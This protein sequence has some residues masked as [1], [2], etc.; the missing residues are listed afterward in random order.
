MALTIRKLLVGA[1]LAG[2]AYAFMAWNA[3]PATIEARML[4]KSARFIGAVQTGDRATVLELSQSELEAIEEAQD[5]VVVAR[6]EFKVEGATS[7][8]APAPKSFLDPALLDELGRQAHAASSYSVNPEPGLPSVTY[9]FDCRGRR[10]RC[11]EHLRITYTANAGKISGWIAFW[12]E[13]A[14][15]Q[16]WSA[17]YTKGLEMKPCG[18]VC[19]I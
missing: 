2:G 9:H 19:A 16:V 5:R 10:E 8:D 18:A 3:A 6:G 13:P 1:V 15:R 17:Y 7:S 4:D 14:W 11:V 12:N